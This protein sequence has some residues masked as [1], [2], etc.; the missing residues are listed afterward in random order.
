MKKSY[1][2][3]FL[4]FL[5]I[6][7]LLFGGRI[8]YASENQSEFYDA[9]LLEDFD[10][11]I[12]D[13]IVGTLLKEN[14]FLVS[15]ENQTDY[16]IQWQNLQ[17]PVPSEILNLDGTHILIEEQSLLEET[18]ITSSEIITIFNEDK[19][20]GS[21]EPN[22]KYPLFDE[23]DEAYKIK[24]G[25]QILQIS[26]TDKV[27]KVS[28]SVENTDSEVN[29]ENFPV[30]TENEDE[31]IADDK[32]ENAISE[33]STSNQISSNSDLTKE[34]DSIRTKLNKSLLT[35]TTREFKPTDKYFKVIEENLGIYDNSSGTLV[36]VGELVSGQTYPR[37]SDYGNWH[38][39]KFGNGYGFVLKSATEPVETHNLKNLNQVSTN[40]KG[41]IKAL[42]N[43][44]VYDNS[45]GD[46]VKFASLNANLSYPI[47]SDY[48]NWYQVDVAGRVGY[49]LK[50]LTSKPFQTSDRYFEVLTDNLGIYDNSSG[51][52]IQVGKLVKGQVYPRISDF[53]NWHQIRFGNGYGYVLKDETKP[54][55]SSLK[56]INGSFT[57]SNNLFTTLKELAVFDNSSGELVQ[58]STLNTNIN[59]PIIGDYGSWHKVD[60]AGR[61]GYVLKADTRQAFKSTD[62]YF[63]VI[64]DNL[65]IFDN[66]T[67]NLVEVGSLVKNQVYLIDSDYGN[68]HKIRY[69]NSYG[70]VY[71]GSTTPD[72]GT[73]IKNINSSTKQSSLKFTVKNEA[74]VVDNT[75]GT[76][77][78]FAT[79]LPNQTLNY[80]EPWGDWLKVD[81]GGRY[82]YVHKGNTQIGLIVS[83]PTLELYDSFKQLSEYT[84][85]NSNNFLKFGEQVEVLSENQYAAQVRT[86]NG[87][88]T[89]WVLKDYL[90]SDLLD[91][92]WYVKEGRN[93]RA[94]Y[95]S[96]S[97]SL[98]FID[99]KTS[100]KVLDYNIGTDP[101]NTGW[102]KIRT[103]DGREGW[104]WGN[105]SNGSN[106]IKYKKENVDAITNELTIFTPL[107]TLSSITALQINQFINNVTK[108]DTSSYMY[109]MGEAYLEA[110]R[111][112]GVNAI[113]LVAHSALE[114]NYG[115]S[116]IVKDKYNYFGIGAFDACP[117]ECSNTF[118]NKAKGIIDGA[119]WIN[120]NYV[121]REAY[122]QFTLDSMRNNSNTHQYATDEAWH[123]KITNIANSFINF[124]KSL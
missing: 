110:Q 111:L 57:A 100:V 45:S 49:V 53:G 29:D 121:S 35:I 30:A 47:L 13:I 62:K 79:L 63:R 54:A 15:T 16:F 112:T 38:Q 46:L 26:K 17:V 75:S 94:S 98:G 80:I 60:V 90:V 102:Y 48:G 116:S 24:L 67:G 65:K 124:I 123:V 20:I 22:I 84:L 5:L 9:T 113:Y 50:E 108:G 6:S 64:E 119:T 43:L 69:G 87:G 101:S 114:T 66:K 68:W 3:I 77:V 2:N 19:V 8:T 27:L 86:L 31:K 40:N 76:L 36:K 109:N 25:N 117:K 70:Y 103:E 28:E 10:I 21:I 58:F 39:V 91:S 99:G 42:E 78:P 96:A 118:D 51:Q 120:T 115:R 106:I 92:W 104:I 107:N 122:Q 37:I 61:I 1:I 14:S 56:N 95:T 32:A 82:G 74:T 105:G 83:S 73:T 34:E 85:Q 33:S 81:I 72:T 18:Y 59:Y 93:L 12:N 97:A 11:V 23:T 7:S 71:K 41:T 55:Q 44:P 89:G 52:L 88:V 4:V